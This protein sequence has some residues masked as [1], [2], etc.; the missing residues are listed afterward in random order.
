MT[1]ESERSSIFVREVEQFEKRRHERIVHVQLDR[2][3]FGRY[4]PPEPVSQ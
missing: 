4:D 1:T 2:D 3:R